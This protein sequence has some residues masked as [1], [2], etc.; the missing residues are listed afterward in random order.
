MSI[1]RSINSA[2]PL[3]APTRS[4]R[5][6]AAIGAALA[7]LGTAVVAG[8]VFHIPGVVQVFPGLTA[9]VLNTALCFVLLGCCMA[10]VA[11][12][13]EWR[14]TAQALPAAVLL[15]AGLVVLQ[16]A[17]GADFGIDAPAFHR[18]L[19][20]DSARSGRMSVFTATAFVAASLAALLAMRPSRPGRDTLALAFAT[21][22][23]AVGVVALLGHLVE[24]DLV[25]AQ[26]STN[27]VAV[28]TAVGLVALSA[29]LWL[30]MLREG[31]V[32]LWQRL[33]VQDRITLAAAAILTLA[34]LA[35]AVIGFP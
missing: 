13:P 14:R 15:L 9:M 12:R 27:L 19:S 11:L 20:P 33:A 17:L 35:T 16:S 6:E 29:G 28:H 23:G 30:R 26:Y 21:V 2:A 3:P 22:A 34:A 8:W 1:Q 4:E 5:A 24:L 31:R 10:L 7:L 18:W 25:Y 32:H